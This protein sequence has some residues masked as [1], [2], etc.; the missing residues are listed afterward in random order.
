MTGI[1]TNDNDPPIPGVDDRTPSKVLGRDPVAPLPKR[2]YAAV[3]TA[4]ASNAA[5][6]DGGYCIQLDGR[7]IKTPRK[8]T[9]CVPSL[10]LAE[11]IACEWHAQTFHI[12]PSTM[13]VTRLANTT[14]DAVVPNL[15]AVRADIVDFSGTDAL[16]YR[17]EGPAALTDLQAATWDPILDWA[18]QAIDARFVTQIGIVHVAQPRETLAAMADAMERFCPWQIAALHVMTT[19]TGS[20]LLAFAVAERSLTL[21]AAWAAA[22]V[23]EDWQITTWGTDD[24]ALARRHLRWLEMQSAAK[25]LETLR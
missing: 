13:P 22:H 12:D 10:E 3:T 9:L 16:C 1:T 18:A 5:A 2:F 20:A 15:A 14:L 6:P 25:V 19:I 23:D 17:A 24:E 4:V 21:D 11:T 7:A 8:T